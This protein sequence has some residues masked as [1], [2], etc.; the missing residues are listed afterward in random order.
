MAQSPFVRV[1]RYVYV[2]E[3][4]FGGPV[5]G[6]TAALAAATRR[7]RGPMTAALRLVLAAAAA[8][9]PVCAARLA[10]RAARRELA[11]G[12]GPRAL[13]PATGGPA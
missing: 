8:L 3:V 10:G 9:L 13:P 11:G 2:E 5:T 1:R 12:R 7:A 4:V 6:D